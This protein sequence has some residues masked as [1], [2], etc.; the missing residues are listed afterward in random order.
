MNIIKFKDQIRQGDE[1]FNKYLKG[2]YAYWVQMRY[3]VPL[4]LITTQDYIMFEQDIKKLIGWRDRH[5]PRPEVCYW[6]LNI[7]HAD[8]VAWV[9]A[10]ETEA[11]NAIGK[12]ELFNTFTT[13]EDLTV[14]QVKKFRTWLAQTL[15]VLDQNMDDTQ[16]N[17]YYTEDETTMLQYYAAGMYNAVIKQLSK[18]PNEFGVAQ[19]KNSACGCGTGSDISNLYGSTGGFCDPIGLYRKYVY[20]QMVSKFSNLDFW[21][22]LPTT[23]VVK[24][25]QYIDCIIRLNLP[26][27]Y[28]EYTSQFA[29]CACMGSG[30]LAK[31]DIL[32][33]LSKSLL[34]IIEDDIQGNKN[35]IADA[36]RDWAT[37]LYENMEWK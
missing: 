30:Q 16:K 13:D 32:N 23:L 10:E 28:S 24:V 34:M 9:D 14:D 18:I 1:L 11:A 2:R 6:D 21:A 29:D 27:I 3:V 25:R 26:L 37:E 20:T 4:E 19:I 35:F 5:L 7:T 22:E 17:V 33:R 8:L 36:L 31:R 12:Y 15:L